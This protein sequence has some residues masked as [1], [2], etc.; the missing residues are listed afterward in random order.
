[1]PRYTHLLLDADGTLFDYDQAEATAL[2]ATFRDLKLGFEAAY[3]EAYRQINGRIWHEFEQGTITAAQIRTERFRRLFAALSLNADPTAFGQR[4]LSRLGECAQ[5]IDG[6]EDTV[7]ALYG[8]VGL[9]LITNG[10][11]DVQRARLSRSPI[12]RYL[13]DVV[14]S[15]EVGSSKPDPGIFDEAFRRMGNPEKQD[16]L[17]VGDSLTSDMQGGRD[18]GIDTCWYNPHARPLTLDM[19]ISYEIAKLDELLEIVQG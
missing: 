5:L 8:I 2:A 4:Y 9:V 11:Q 1:M 18:Y 17:I 12:A 10:L 6:V 16:V 15:E 14:I 7:A 3:A 13:D 19:A